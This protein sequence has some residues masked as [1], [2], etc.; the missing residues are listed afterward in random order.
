MDLNLN[1]EVQ[2]ALLA[3]YLGDRGGLLKP[4]G[5][6]AFTL[7]NR[8]FQEY[9]AACHLTDG[10]FPGLIAELAR[11]EPERWREVV[12]LAAAKAAR[13]SA[14]ALWMLIDRLCFRQPDDPGADL[15]DAWGA[16]FAGQVIQESFDL[17]AVSRP[18]RVTLDLVRQWLVRVLRGPWLPACERVVA[19]N[20]LAR[21]GDRKGGAGA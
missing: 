13:G 3:E 2:P 11:S 16:H 15:S 10:E 20:T 14:A 8:T 9:L 1:P 12:L 6:G 21:I 18:R 17:S 5:I 4:R 19:G 7:P